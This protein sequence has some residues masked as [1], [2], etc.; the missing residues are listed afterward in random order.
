MFKVIVLVTR[1]PGMSKADFIHHYENVHVPMVRRFFPQLIDYR[2]NYVELDGAM[3]FEG[4]AAPDFDSVT[5][6][7]FNDRAGY[8]ELAAANDDPVKG[9]QL[10]LDA[11][12]FMDTT[13]TRLLVVEEKGA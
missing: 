4:A 11:E 7:W 12:L 8:E 13:K 6:M 9:P 2:R 5:E 3:I 10:A 1:K